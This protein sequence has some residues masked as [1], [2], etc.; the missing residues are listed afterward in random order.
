MSLADVLQCAAPISIFTGR[1][2]TGKTEVAIN[3]ALALAVG[4]DAVRLTDMDVVTP[5]YRSREM[6]ER[7][8]EKGVEVVCVQASKVDRSRL[9][10]WL[11]NNKIPFATGMIDGDEEKVKLNWRVKSLPWLILTDSEHLV[12][13]E[14][15]GI[16]E[17]EEKMKKEEE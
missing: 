12:T 4:D 7:L 6:T 15:F 17:L 3:Y 1:F 14:G 10:Q 8:D 9:D 16:E 5:Y 2:G 11:K 13:D